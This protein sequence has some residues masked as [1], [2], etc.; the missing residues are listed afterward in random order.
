MEEIAR[1]DGNRG[2]EAVA[3]IWQGHMLDLLG[4]R[5]EA[6][7]RYRRVVDMNLDDGVQHS[8]YALTYAYSP[9]A[10]ERLEEPFQRIENGIQ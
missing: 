5:Q 3:L 8:Q 6:L 10:A 7:E 1:L 2:R 4:R 9:Y